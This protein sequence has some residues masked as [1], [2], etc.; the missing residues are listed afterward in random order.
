MSDLWQTILQEASLGGVEFPLARRRWTG[1]RDGA[2][3][4]FPHQPG[5]GVD[6]TGRKPRVLEL[7]IELFADVDETHYPGKFRDLVSLFESDTLL[8]EVEYVDPILAP[9]PVKVWG[10]DVEEEATS[11]NG[12]VITVQLEEVSQ[13][14]RAAALTPR[15][16]SRVV[17]SETALDLDENLAELGVTDDDVSESFEKAGAP[18]AGDVEKG[19]PAGQKFAALT[20]A[21]LEGLDSG[22]RTVD[23]VAAS[24]DIVRRRV[25]SVT[26]LAP[27]RTSSG[28]SAYASALQLVDALAELAELA[29]S[30][31]VAI[32][33]VA[34]NAET[35]AVELATKLY[36]D[37]TRAE[38]IIRRNPTRRPN[39]YPAGTVI[40]VAER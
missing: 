24:A 20:T 10:F 1:G 27:L 2:R 31:A 32:V 11:R 23:E 29:S 39:A 9:M 37:R 16:S 13:D 4:E 33:E 25:A 18:L 28:W 3:L 5:Q 8:G 38:E 12:A 14:V 17:A 26:A 19:W 36:G 15:R 7:V 21:F 35:S 6:D 30:R 34:L 22:L 40:R